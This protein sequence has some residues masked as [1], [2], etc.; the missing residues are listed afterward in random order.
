MREGPGSGRSPRPPPS[1]HL[2]PPPG[3]PPGFSSHPSP[4]LFK[5]K[6]KPGK[7]RFSQA[8]WL[9]SAESQGSF[10]YLTSL[11]TRLRV[12]RV[13]WKLWERRSWNKRPLKL[14]R[15][16]RSRRTKEGIL[17][18]NSGRLTQTQITKGNQ[19]PI[20]PPQVRTFRRE[21]QL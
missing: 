3:C 5:S 6:Q 7:T 16:C 12:L 10:R 1:Q 18:G 11:Q 14:V 4:I 20:C 2:P 19:S 21:S 15:V 13:P 8:T 9:T 17:A